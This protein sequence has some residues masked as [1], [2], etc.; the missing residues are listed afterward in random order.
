MFLI[1]EKFSSK[2]SDSIVYCLKSSIN[3]MN[4]GVALGDSLKSLGND[5]I[6]LFLNFNLLVMIC[7]MGVSLV[8]KKQAEKNF[9]LLL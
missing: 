5:Y 6:F 7:R 4:S 8:W 9:S 1:F 3:L 2:L